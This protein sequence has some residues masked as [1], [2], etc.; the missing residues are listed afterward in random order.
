MEV[1]RKRNKEL[2]LV[3]TVTLVGVTENNGVAVLESCVVVEETP[4][5][6]EVENTKVFAEDVADILKLMNRFEFVVGVEIEVVEIEVFEIEVVEIEVVE[7]E[8]AEFEV[9]IDTI[10]DVIEKTALCDPVMLDWL[11]C[12]PMPTHVTK[13]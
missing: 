9:S 6:D 2:E 7:I 3:E 11:F 13:G 8:V 12:A 5:I 4:V 10:V 1:V